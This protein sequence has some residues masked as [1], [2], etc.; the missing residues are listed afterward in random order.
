MFEFLEEFFNF[1]FFTNNAYRL[2]DDNASVFVS[3]LLE[4]NF[5]LNFVKFQYEM[6][7]YDFNIE[8]KRDYCF[9][10]TFL[11]MYKNSHFHKSTRSYQI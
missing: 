8:K 5:T 6:H 10:K 11:I 2:R 7:V 4:D 9:I 3:N 1:Y